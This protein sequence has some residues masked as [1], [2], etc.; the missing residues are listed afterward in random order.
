MPRFHFLLSLSFC[1][2]PTPISQ[3]MRSEDNDSFAGLERLRTSIFMMCINNKYTYVYTR[4]NDIGT[5][6]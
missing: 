2:L 5:H 6:T 4:L 3:D 1:S